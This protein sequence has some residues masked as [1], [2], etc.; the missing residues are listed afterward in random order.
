[1]QVILTGSHERFSALVWTFKHGHNFWTRAMQDSL[2]GNYEKFGYH[3]NLKHIKS[4]AKHVSVT[5]CASFS[6]FHQPVQME[7]SNSD[8]HQPSIL[9]FVLFCQYAKYKIFVFLLGF[10][11]A[12]YAWQNIVTILF[13]ART[14]TR[15]NHLLLSRMGWQIG[16]LLGW[17][18]WQPIAHAW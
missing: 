8:F 1:M 18:L 13:R 14:S 15:S 10:L 5:L 3:R 9:C 7:C 16:F 6:T 4:G 2:T 12:K 11:N 17:W